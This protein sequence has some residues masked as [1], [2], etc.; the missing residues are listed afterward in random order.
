M[1]KIITDIFAGYDPDLKRARQTAALRS[2]RRPT[3][4]DHNIYR[5]DSDYHTSELPLKPAAVLIPLV[6]HKD[7]MTVLLTKRAQHL[8][9]H[10]GQVSF[11]GGRCE[12][13]DAD[14]METALRETEE[15]VGIK[16]D[17]I[18]VLGGME[19]YETVTGYVITPIVAIIQPTYRLKV[20]AGEVAEAFELPLDYILDEKNHKLE[21]RVWNEQRRHYYVLMNEKHNVWGATAAMLVRFAKLINGHS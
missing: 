3:Y 15:E 11:P 12:P 7:G 13:E 21:S 20:D 16:R 6:D 1:R 9:T 18:D 8:K 17:H 19:D 10:S 2:M 5:P 14:A 4:G